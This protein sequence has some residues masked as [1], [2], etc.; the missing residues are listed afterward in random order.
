MK[1]S[2]AMLTHF[3][4][5]VCVCVVVHGNIH[6]IIIAH[7][8]PTNFVVDAMAIVFARESSK[9]LTKS[10]ISSAPDRMK[11]QPQ[12]QQ[13]KDLSRLNEVVFA[14]CSSEQTTISGEK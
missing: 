8:I 14:E 1:T 7:K 12:Q 9:S 4:N 5:I 13:Q 6:P 3:N 2:T 11:L 10:R